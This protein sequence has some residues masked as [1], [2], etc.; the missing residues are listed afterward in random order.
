MPAAWLLLPDMVCLWAR[1]GA[2]PATPPA[3][4]AA[5]KKA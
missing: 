3:P 5:K 4:S 2:A 1:P